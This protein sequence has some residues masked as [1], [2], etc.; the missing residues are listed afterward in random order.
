[1]ENKDVDYEAHRAHLKF[2]YRPESLVD[3]H[4]LGYIVDSHFKTER[5]HE[6]RGTAQAKDRTG[7]TQT[8][9]LF[10]AELFTVFLT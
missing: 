5:R 9:M 1:M 4:V 7:V 10:V 8:C 3:L 2:L 6:F